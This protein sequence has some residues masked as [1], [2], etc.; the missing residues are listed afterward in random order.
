MNMLEPGLNTSLE[1]AQD[2]YVISVRDL[3][4]ILWRRLWVIL[5]VTALLTGAAVGLDL[6]RTPTYEATIKILVGQKQ[7]SGVPG[8]LGGDVMGLQQLTQTMAEAVPTRPVA[9]AVIDR[10]DLGMSSEAFLGNLRVEQVGTT[11]FIEV[12]YE[13]ESP[14]KAKQIADAVGTVFSDQVSEVSPSANSITAT[15]WEAAAVPASP[16]SPNPLRDAL[17]ALVLGG[18]L[19]IGIAFLLELLDDRWRSPEEVERV[20]GVPTFGVIP[21]FKAAKRKKGVN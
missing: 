21:E 2:E 7:E 15:V 14:E 1:T 18:M 17:L 3:L 5:L 10:L 6:L 4:G 11:Q 9:E 13:D 16:V 20:S 8:S 12:S 19:G